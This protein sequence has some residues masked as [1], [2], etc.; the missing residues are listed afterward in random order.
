MQGPNGL[1]STKRINK[2]SSLSNR[3]SL[4]KSIEEPEAHPTIVADSQND[5]YFTTMQT[6]PDEL[7]TSSYD[8]STK[9]FQFSHNNRITN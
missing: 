1:N 2:A 6:I 9:S 4:I 3:D 8:K 5:C 7:P